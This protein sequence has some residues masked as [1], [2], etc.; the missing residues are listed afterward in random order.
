MVPLFPPLLPE[1]Q[2]ESFVAT[3]A[4]QGSFLV[5]GKREQT[6]RYDRLQS[7]ET[8]PIPCTN[9]RASEAHRVSEGALV[10]PVDAV[11]G[12]RCME[13]RN[14]SRSVSSFADRN[15]RFGLASILDERT[16]MGYFVDPRKCYDPCTHPRIEEPCNKCYFWSNSLLFHSFVHDSRLHRRS[17]GLDWKQQRRRQYGSRH[18]DRTKSSVSGKGS[19]RRIR[20][21]GVNGETSSSEGQGREREKWTNHQGEHL[22][23]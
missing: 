2:M 14:L 23:S 16:R 19:T 21:K 3:L 13:F 11:I 22:Q 18:F 6:F 15:H 1:F 12:A 17:L 5:A 4:T 10:L 20:S 8:K 7:A 9:R